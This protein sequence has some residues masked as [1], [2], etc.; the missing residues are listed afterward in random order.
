MWLCEQKSI[1]TEQFKRKTLIEKGYDKLL[2]K[3]MI[4]NYT[5]NRKDKDWFDHVNSAVVWKTD[6]RYNK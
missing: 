3:F 4:L 5:N 2:K 1:L 6:T